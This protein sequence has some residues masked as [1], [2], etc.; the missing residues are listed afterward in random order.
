V[1]DNADQLDALC[2]HA[3]QL[4]HAVPGRVSRVRVQA[5]DLSVDL[6]WPQT[7][8]VPGTAGP[9]APTPVPPAAG[10]DLPGTFTVRAPMLG[11]FFRQPEPG[12]EPFI[13]I[14]DAVEAG[15]QVAIVEAMKLMY[16]LKA[17][18]S[19]HV[20]DILVPDGAPVEYDQALIVLAEPEKD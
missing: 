6:Q 19:G 1:T 7:A 4:V 13:E 20:V 9:A 10:V 11:T 8:D 12:A 18:R 14:G 3:V 15:Q 16:P 5:G 2:R 17:D